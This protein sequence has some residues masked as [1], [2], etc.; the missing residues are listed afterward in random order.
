MQNDTCLIVVMLARIQAC[1]VVLILTS[2]SGGGEEKS[3]SDL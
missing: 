1:D 2:I 3:F